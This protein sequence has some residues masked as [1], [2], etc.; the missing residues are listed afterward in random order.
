MLYILES[1]QEYFDEL[2]DEGYS[3]K[4]IEAELIRIRLENRGFVRC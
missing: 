4:E 1:E 3:L 2:L